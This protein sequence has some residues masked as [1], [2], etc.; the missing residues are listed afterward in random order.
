MK[1][2]KVLVFHPELCE[3]DGAC[4]R[5]C[6]KVQYFRS[7]EGGDKSALRVVEGKSGKFECTVCNQCGLCVDNCPEEAIIK[8]EEKKKANKK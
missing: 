1:T 5:A 4:E 6:S 2:V 7:D 8:V 3:G